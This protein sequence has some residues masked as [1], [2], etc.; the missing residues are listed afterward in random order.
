MRILIIED[1]PDIAGNIGDY[2]QLQGHIVDFASDGLLGLNLAIEHTFDAII[3]DINMPRM[4]GFEVCRQL[5]GEHQ[6]DTPVLMLT[7][8]DSLADKTTG[9]ELGA[10]DYLVKPFELKELSMRLDALKLRQAPNRSRTLSV[11]DLSLNLDKW[12]AVRGGKVLN[13]HRASLRVLEMLMRASPNAVSRQDIEFFL[14]GDNPPSSD[15]LRSHMYE[16]RR[17]LD[18]PFALKML[19]TMRGIGFALSADGGKHGD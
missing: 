12:Q 4:D 10:W 9:F 16:L 6:L 3:L 8:R 14:W 2:L 15:P 19:K 18:K 7:A 1:N 5:R 13:L 11:G 17:E